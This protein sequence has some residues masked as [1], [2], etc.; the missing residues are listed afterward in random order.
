[1]PDLAD[2]SDEQLAERAASGVPM[3][4][5]WVDAADVSAAVLYLASDAARYVT[6]TVL[7]VDGGS[8]IP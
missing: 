3:G 8:A 2:P 5:P 4:I 7:P 1:V 6:G